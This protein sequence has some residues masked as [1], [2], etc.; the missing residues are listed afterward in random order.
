MAVYFTLA[1]DCGKSH[2]LAERIAQHFREF[3]I[4]PVGIA[5]VPC[6][7]W[8]G[9]QRGFCMVVVWPL[10]LGYACPKG[11]R[12]D[13]ILDPDVI[14]FIERELHSRLSAVSGYRAALFGREAQEFLELSE[15]PTEDELAI[16][17]MIYD[18][19]LVSG[20]FFKRQPFFSKGYKW[21]PE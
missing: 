8:V 18:E 13:N 6:D 10:G 21:I 11:P 9:E 2:D 3:Q 17:G 7:V 4:E 5:P 16:V 15:A 20:E 12:R 19:S 1:I 14:K